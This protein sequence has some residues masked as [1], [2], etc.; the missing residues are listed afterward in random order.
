MKVSG[1]NVRV[2]DSILEGLESINAQHSMK[3]HEQSL[4][5]EIFADVKVEKMFSI[6]LT[7]DEGKKL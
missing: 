1:A 3:D 6:P 5:G 7:T 4:L 2:H